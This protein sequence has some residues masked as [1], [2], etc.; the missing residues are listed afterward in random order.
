MPAIFK[1][2]KV[3]V[4]IWPTK[5]I[6]EW[7]PIIHIGTG[8]D[9]NEHGDKNPAIFFKPNKTSLY[10]SSSV[11][12]NANYGYDSLQIP[13][14]NWTTVSVQQEKAQFL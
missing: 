6:S 8:R 5:L 2:Y 7:G 10:I 1:Y 4:D 13:L 14:K 12:E 9:R 3:S 11:N